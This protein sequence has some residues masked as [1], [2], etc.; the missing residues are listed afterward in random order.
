MCVGVLSAGRVRG[1][2]E[3]GSVGFMGRE[4][5]RFTR[6]CVWVRL[7]PLLL[8]HN[9]FKTGLS[10]SIFICSRWSYLQW[11]NLVNI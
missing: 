8:K 4:W 1:C 6:A 7:L 9:S 3:F 5:A 2:L 10:K 11:G